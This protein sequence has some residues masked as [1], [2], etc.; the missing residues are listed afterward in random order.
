MWP[1]LRKVKDENRYELVLMGEDVNKKIENEGLDP[2][3]CHLTQLNFLRV[4][5]SPLSSV[6]ESISL[7][8]NLTNLVL[9]GNKLESLSGAVGKLDK[10]KVLDVSRN[11]LET[12]PEEIGQ[13]TR[14]TTLNVSF[15]KLA[16]LPCLKECIHLALLDVRDNCLTEFPDVAQDSLA[17]LADIKFARNNI[18]EI[19]VS[20][21]VLPSLKL[22]DLEGN[23]IKVVPGDLID[24]VKLK[25]LN[26]KGNPL[27]DRRFRKL[28]ESD[29][30]LPKQV[31]DYVRQHCPKVHVQ[32]GKGGGKG[33]KGKGGK[34]K[35]KDQDQMDE[36]CNELHVLSLTEETPP[37]RVDPV[38]KDVRPYI[39]CCI[40][41]KIDLNGENFKKFISLQTKLHEGICEKRLAATIATHDLAKIK[42]PLKYTA[43]DPKEIL[44]H[45][46][47]RGKEVTA[48]ALHQALQH[49]AE[50]Q[51]KQMKKNSITGIHKYLH[52]VESWN[53]WP[54]IEDSAGTVVS[55][56]PIT[57]AENTKITEETTDVFIEVTSSRTLG[58]TKEVLDAL[59]LAILQSNICPEK[60]EA[61]K[62]VMT[63]QQ[64]RV[65]DE[66]GKLRVLYP[67]RTDLTY[68]NEKI[69]V[70]MPE[71]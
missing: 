62:T 31:L 21:H 13:L 69:R 54:C 27:S 48:K 47:I 51:R 11:S 65:E 12:L 8:A 49:E 67:S 40:L 42:G 53:V 26:L 52:I 30:C 59:L 6:P 61:D 17:L 9:D 14:L 43:R 18:S 37:I 35:N 41:R 10:L 63:I 44:I 19:P 4:S 64:V 58:K 71:K 34:G 15:N 66:D 1:E 36:M 60:N 32:E 5:K 3:L 33:K 70:V 25:E 24:C 23:N 50:V 56:P 29:R 57:N 22:L 68:E 28:V 39:A 2:D 38:V 45:P 20:I 7:L 55:L 16:S 46:L